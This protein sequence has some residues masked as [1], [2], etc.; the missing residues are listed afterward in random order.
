MHIVK[1]SKE[2]KEKEKEK[3]E[4]EEL[5]GIPVSIAGSSTDFMKTGSLCP[6]TI[7]LSL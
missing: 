6:R 5:G 1:G 4:E 3:E 7:S 2:G